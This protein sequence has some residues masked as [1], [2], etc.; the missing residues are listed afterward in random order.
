MSGR[1]SSFP[2]RA[3]GGRNPR[4]K[5]SGTL[6]NGVPVEECQKRLKKGSLFKGS[7]FKGPL[8]R[9]SYLGLQTLNMALRIFSRLKALGA[10]GI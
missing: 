5:I 10:I 1:S 9:L 2:F 6:A 4:Y 3:G 8:I 7:P